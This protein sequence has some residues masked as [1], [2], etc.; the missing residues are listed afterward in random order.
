MTNETIR[1]HCLGLPHVTEVVQWEDHLLFK[2]GGKMFAIIALD[3]HSCTLRCTPEKYAEL[4]EMA[5]VVP[6]SHNMWKYHWVTTETLTAVPDR[7]LRAL[8]TASYEI[9]R[10]GLAKNIRAELDAGRTPVIAPWTSRKKGGA[11]KKKR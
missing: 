6:S 5:D 10:A 9:V 11:G 8:L 1:E 4:V 7:E 3:G 2:I